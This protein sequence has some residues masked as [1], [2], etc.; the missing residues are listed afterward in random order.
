L[1]TPEKQQEQVRAVL[2]FGFEMSRN[3][4]QNAAA[5]AI[6]QQLSTSAEGEQESPIRDEKNLSRLSLQKVK[7]M[8]ARVTRQPLKSLQ[9]VTEIEMLGSAESLLIFLQEIQKFPI[10]K[11]ANFWIAF[12]TRLIEIW[13]NSEDYQEKYYTEEKF[14]IA[15]RNF[16]IV[17]LL[18]TKSIFVQNNIDPTE[19]QLYPDIERINELRSS[20]LYPLYSH[21]ELERIQ[22]TT[23]F[24]IGCSTASPL[25][26][27]LARMG[28]KKIILSD[29]DVV[30]TSNTNRGTFDQSHLGQNKALV[31]A[32]QILLINPTCQVQ[33]YPFKLSLAELTKIIVNDQPLIINEA[34]DSL[35]TKLIIRWLL[36]ALSKLEYKTPI[37]G[38]PTNID[39][40]VLSI[41]NTH[42]RTFLRPEMSEADW[43]RITKAA[44]KHNMRQFIKGVAKIIA[45]KHISPR[46]M[47]NFILFALSF[48][49]SKHSKKLEG[50][51]IYEP[52]KQV[53][54]I[55]QDGISAI[56]A[57]GAMG[58][59]YMNLI[60]G[61]T[62]QKS[63]LQ[64][65][66]RDMF[67]RESLDKMNEPYF[68]ELQQIY[69][70]IFGGYSNLNEALAHLV[71]LIFGEKYTYQ[72]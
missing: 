46:Q 71:P 17:D 53:R 6:T 70:Q 26:L 8:L 52:D 36:K 5:I 72:L 62:T 64:I 12:R 68:A 29:F 69:P 40:S 31:V 44:A 24:F 13:K 32:Q 57:A 51:F 67:Q 47:V 37:L 14:L 61:A 66:V 41:E 2:G 20:R 23:F 30:E 34:I 1:K 28:V 45:I 42:D 25:I 50:L 48:R 43:S 54:Y 11:Q 16:E 35:E 39:D 65:S 58:R 55:S 4:F 21:E 15:Y 33:V 27:A 18:P 10:L 49:D 60:Q 19:I 3:T 63:E 22:N 7:E 38:M 56:S 59:I 9:L